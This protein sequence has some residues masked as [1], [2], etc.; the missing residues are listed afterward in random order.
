MTE[1]VDVFV[2][3]ERTIPSRAFRLSE[4][5]FRHVPWKVN[6]AQGGILLTLLN[7]T[8][9]GSSVFHRASTDAASANGGK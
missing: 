2:R 4:A 5:R 1:S 7:V 6:A 8:A 3:G 9:Y